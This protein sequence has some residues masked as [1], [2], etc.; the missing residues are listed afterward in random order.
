MSREHPFLCPYF[1]ASRVFLDHG[2]SGIRMVPSSALRSCAETIA[3]KGVAPRD[4]LLF[5][6]DLC[7]YETMLQAARNSDV[8]ILNFFHLFDEEIQEQ[9]Y[10]SLGIIP[11]E[12]LLLMDEAH[13]CGDAAQSVQSVILEE[14]T[15]CRMLVTMNC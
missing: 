7:P 10:A 5:C 8:I 12:T 1:I 13:N 11:E 9:I 4:L 14:K 2:D 3:N 6:G 15:L